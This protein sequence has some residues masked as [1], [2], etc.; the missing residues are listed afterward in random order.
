M[1]R[2]MMS[3]RIEGKIQWED[4]YVVGYL[5]Y[6]KPLRMVG[7]EMWWMVARDRGSCKKGLLETESDCGM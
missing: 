6:C 3:F 4:Q 1:P 2:R 5:M 7:F